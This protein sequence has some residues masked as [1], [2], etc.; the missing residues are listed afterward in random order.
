MKNN[1]FEFTNKMLWRILAVILIF[2][3]SFMIIW[4]YKNKDNT[5]KNNLQISIINVLN[6]NYSGIVSYKDYDKSNHNNPTIYLTNGV[7]FIEGDYW[8]VIKKGDSLIKK[9]GDFFIN[10]YRNDSVFKL[11]KKIYLEDDLN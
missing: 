11:D 7:K 1:S 3:I 8:D 6:Q 10:V 5:N 9:R 2:F 4:S